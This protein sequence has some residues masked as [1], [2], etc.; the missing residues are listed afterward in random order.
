[1]DRMTA[2][3][4]PAE[5][6]TSEDMADRTGRCACGAV[7][8]RARTPKTFGVCH[9]RTCRRWV[10]GVWMGVRCDGQ[11]EVKGP[12]KVWTSSGIADRAS[13]AECGSAIWHRARMS[14]AT[15]LGLGL[16]DDQEGWT[17][18]RQIFVEEQPEH[19]GFGSKGVALTGWGTF[20]ALIS[21]KMPK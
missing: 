19:Y 4:E 16:F 7:T 5:V 21:G 20:W 11:P 15:T 13:C 12:V 8:I 18:V 14:K 6:S 17:M 3:M 9:C 2:N 1:M 10:G